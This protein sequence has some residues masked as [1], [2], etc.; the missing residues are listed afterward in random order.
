MDFERA[1]VGVFSQF[2]IHLQKSQ[3]HKIMDFARI[4]IKD[5][6]QFLIQKFRITISLGSKTKHHD[7]HTDQNHKLTTFFDPLVKNC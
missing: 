6:T 2:K 3:D 1:I 7:F 5:Q 4:K